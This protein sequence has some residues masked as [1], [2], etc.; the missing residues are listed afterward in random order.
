MLI[1][2]DNQEKSYSKHTLSL[3]SEKSLVLT[4]THSHTHF[5]Y[6]AAVAQGVEQVVE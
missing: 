5:N 1:I 3:M 4:H 2:L 6:E